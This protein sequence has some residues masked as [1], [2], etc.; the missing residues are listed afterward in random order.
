MCLSSLVL[1]TL[2]T[3]LPMTARAAPPPVVPADA[4]ADVRSFPGILLPEKT[5]LIKSRRDERVD[6]VAV[7]VGRGVREGQ[8]LLRLVTDEAR[9]SRDR[10]AAVLEQARADLE[11]IRRLHA[12][13]LTS[14]EALE[15]G[16][17][18]LKLAEADYQLAALHLEDCTIRAPFEGV[19]A[20]LYV[21]SGTSV[22]E[23]D[24]LVRVTALRPL[25]LEAFLPEEM[26]SRFSGP[27]VVTLTPAYPDTTL[28]LTVELRSPVVDPGSGTFQLQVRLANREGRLIPGVSCRV[29]VSAPPAEAP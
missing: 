23:G 5:A 16:M 26:L 20:E 3:L 15:S 2:L 4:P 24:R 14:D 7:V 28:H 27:T 12:E 22:E 25:R 8:V 10:A 29:T 17:T 21:D 19:V 11:R 1:L 18:G 6:S 13:H 9:F